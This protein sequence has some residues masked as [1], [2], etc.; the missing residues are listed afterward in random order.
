MFFHTVF[1]FTFLQN[2]KLFRII[3]TKH[4]KTKKN[5]HINQSDISGHVW[6]LKVIHSRQR[7]YFI[8]IPRASSL[9]CHRCDGDAAVG[10]RAT[11]AAAAGSSA[12]G[13]AIGYHRSSHLDRINSTIPTNSGHRPRMLLPRKLKARI[14]PDCYTDCTGGLL[15]E[16]SFSRV[17]SIS[18]I[19]MTTV[20]AT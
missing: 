4:S 17:L 10:G 7:I 9:D 6:W 3:Q 12:T 1:L 19:L 20:V 13:T 18:E 15:I 5:A 8:D 2:K 11:A 14:L 16:L